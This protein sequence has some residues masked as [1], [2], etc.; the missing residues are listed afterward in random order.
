MCGRGWQER[1]AEGVSPSN[2]L[3]SFPRGLGSE[4]SETLPVEKVSFQCL[5]SGHLGGSWDSK[6]AQL[7]MHLGER[8]LLPNLGDLGTGLERLS[9]A[10]LCPWQLQLP[11]LPP[12][13]GCA[14][15]F[16][17]PWVLCWPL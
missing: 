6:A 8:E 9:A 12:S 15:G 10:S 1:G 4:R 14:V 5:G 16:G 13:R 7:K 17:V 11:S 2:A 3:Q